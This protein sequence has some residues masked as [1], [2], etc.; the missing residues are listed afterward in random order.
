MTVRALGSGWPNGWNASDQRRRRQRGRTEHGRR[1]RCKVIHER[2][3]R[4]GRPEQRLRRRAIRR[5]PSSTL[6]KFGFRTT[7][8]TRLP[9][10]KCRIDG[11]RRTDQRVQRYQCRPG[12]LG[13]RQ[14]QDQ[15]RQHHDVVDGGWSAAMGRCRG[16][17]AV[18][19]RRSSST[20]SAVQP[21]PPATNPI[22]GS[23]ITPHTARTVTSS[24]AA[25][26]DLN[27]RASTT[28]S[29]V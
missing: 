12:L 23:G 19:H 15:C 3:S 11:Q 1:G 13:C 17:A 5:T 4:R 28:A 22:V 6:T 16:S 18:C 10:T 29:V 14:H 8:S 25:N 20:R 2:F 24:P 7:S 26:I 27:A 9:T 21:S